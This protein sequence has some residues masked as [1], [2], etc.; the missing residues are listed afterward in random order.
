MIP[1]EK[2]QKIANTFHKYAETG[3][4]SLIKDYK[5]EDIELSLIQSS[6]DKGWPHYNAM[7]KRISELK[8]I[9]KERKHI[10]EKWK[11]RIIGFFF[12]VAISVVAGLL[13]YLMTKK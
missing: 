1:S 6:A 4:E 8:E 5:C 10:K 13:L 9:E 11:D 3:D 7:E 2:S 12:G